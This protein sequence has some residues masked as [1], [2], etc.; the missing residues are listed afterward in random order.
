MGVNLI[1]KSKVLVA[2]HKPCIQA[3]CCIAKAKIGFRL[4]LASKAIAVE[5]TE[6]ARHLY[7]G[8][9]IAGAAPMP[10][11]VP[12]CWLRLGRSRSDI[13]LCIC[14]KKQSAAC[15]DALL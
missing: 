13:R 1:G 3:W 6:D 14:M 9:Q 15:N 2:S 10:D 7:D 12:Y 8:F 4:I 5:H 11:T